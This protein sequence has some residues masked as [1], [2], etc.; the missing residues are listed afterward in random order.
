MSKR[1]RKDRKGRK[2]QKKPASSPGPTKPVSVV[3]GIPD[4]SKGSA[5]GRL[6]WIVAIFAAWIA[7]L[8]YCKIAGSP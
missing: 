3:D 6:V 4:R 1:P 5:V 7:F 8:V 2:P